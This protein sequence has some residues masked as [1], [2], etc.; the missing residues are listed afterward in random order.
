MWRMATDNYLPRDIQE[1]I[2]SITNA[3]NISVNTYPIPLVT[4]QFLDSLL[5][6]IGKQV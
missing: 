3:R 6:V 2:L 1:N 5:A 4:I